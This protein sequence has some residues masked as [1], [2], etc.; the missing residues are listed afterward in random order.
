MAVKA[1]TVWCGPQVNE[2][3]SACAVAP[4]VEVVSAAGSGAAETLFRSTDAIWDTGAT[5]SVISERLAVRLNVSRTGKIRAVNANATHHCD[6]CF[7]NIR[8]PG[9]I[10]CPPLKVSIQVL[11]ETYDVLIGMDIIG[12]GDFAVSHHEGRM[13]FSFRKPPGGCLD[14]SSHR[15]DEGDAIA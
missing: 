14:F 6:T 8:L 12:K 4:T 7:V 15:P 10:E 13:L 11:Q 9:E 1:F 5:H 2:L 3:K